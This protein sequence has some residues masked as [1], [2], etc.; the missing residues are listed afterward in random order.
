MKLAEL[1]GLK[2]WNPTSPR[3]ETADSAESAEL[4][5][6][7]NPQPLAESCGKKLIPLEIRS[8]PQP[9]AESETYVITGFQAKSANPQNPQPLIAE[10]ALPSS[11]VY[12][13]SLGVN[14]LPDDLTFLRNRLPG[15]TNGRNVSVREYIRRWHEA[16]D[17]EPVNYRKDNAGRYAANTWLRVNSACK[18]KSFDQ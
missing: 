5:R 18:A 11:I 7:E 6:L 8:N 16:M 2:T 13:E 17:A 12:F 3:T 4:C 14:L 10:Q 9:C 15:D 1:L